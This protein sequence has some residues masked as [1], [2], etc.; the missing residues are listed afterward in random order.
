MFEAY[1]VASAAL[2]PILNRFFPILREDYSFWLVIVLYLAF[3]IG[4]L[5]LHTAVFVVSVLLINKKSEKNRF[6]GYYR[7][8]L[9]VTLPLIYRLARVKVHSSGEELLPENKRFLLVCNHLHDFDPAIML[10]SVPDAQLA[11]VAK[12]EAFDEFKFFSRLMVKLDCVPIDRENNREAVK[13]IID[14]AKLIK[15]D[16]ASVCIFP[17]GYTSKTEEL[18]PFRNGAFKVAYKAQCPIAVASMVGT[19]KI[20]K[21]MFRRKTNVYFDIIKV[22]DYEDFKD[23]NTTE[24]GEQIFELIKETT[25]RRKKQEQNV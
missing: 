4:F 23:L 15:N 14:A 2:I 7:K 16:V 20:Q 3:F 8:L 1:I 9:A 24:L 19:R 13:A 11:F 21:N 6:S 17:E 12:K 22:I 18:L 25:D 5:L 10:S